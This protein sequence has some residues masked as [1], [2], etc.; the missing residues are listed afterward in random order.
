MDGYSSPKGENTKDGYD[1][2]LSY[3]F[4]SEDDNRKRA[5]NNHAAYEIAGINSET[6]DLSGNRRRTNLR[7]IWRSDN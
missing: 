3:S 7:R 2:G 4:F 6:G 1:S 5:G